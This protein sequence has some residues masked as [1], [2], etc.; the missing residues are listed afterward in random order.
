MGQNEREKTSFVFIIQIWLMES[1][2][3]DDYS[4]D[5]LT[6]D[7]SRESDFNFDSDEL[8]DDLQELQISDE[9]SKEDQ[10]DMD[11]MSESHTG[12]CGFT[13]ISPSDTTP[14]AVFRSFFTEEIL[15]LI[16]EQTNTY[17]K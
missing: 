13:S 3:S 7:E 6:S 15:N 10:M 9:F 16:V 4:L 2:D 8:V 14:I 12:D 1:F 11:S 17:G 5:S